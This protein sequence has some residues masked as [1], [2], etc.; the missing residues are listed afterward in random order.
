[1]RILIFVTRLTG[2][3]A[4]RVATLWA[5]GFVSRGHEVGMVVRCQHTDRSFPLSDQV[6]VINIWSNLGRLFQKY[7]RINTAPIRSIRQAI[8]QFQPDVAICVLQPWGEWVLKASKGLRLP[9]INT[10]H[11]TWEKPDN[12]VYG[13]LTS[14]RLYWRYELNQQ[15]DCV[16]VLTEAD[17]QCAEGTLSNV[18]VMPNPL[19]FTPVTSVPP[20][21]H[22]MLAAGRLDVWHCKGFDLLLEAWGAIAKDRPDW[23]LVIGGLD[24]H[25]AQKYLMSIVREKQIEDQVE[26]PGYQEDMQPLYQSASIFV[27]SS[28]YEGFGMVLIEAMSQGCAPIACDYKGRQQEIITNENEGLLCPPEDPVALS[29]AMARMIDDEDYRQTVQK[30]AIARSKHFSLDRIMDKWETIFKQI[31]ENRDH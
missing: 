14:Q 11:S 31:N 7:L 2:G 4:E 6:T 25:G 13:Q 30:H 22:V 21:K 18:V 9:I 10:E 26:F 8:N 24:S 15:F 5:N 12:A 20:K 23:K 16:T 1:M 17:K 3:G 27:L 29:Q 19:S 28:R